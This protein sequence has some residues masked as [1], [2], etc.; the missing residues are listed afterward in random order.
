MDIGDVICTQTRH[1]YP[2]QDILRGQ[3]HGERDHKIH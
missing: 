2:A 1:M 3:S